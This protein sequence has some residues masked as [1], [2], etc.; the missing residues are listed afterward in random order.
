LFVVR[1]DFDR[2]SLSDPVK[3]FS[4]WFIVCSQERLRQRFSV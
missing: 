3:D 2:G 1:R 4:Q